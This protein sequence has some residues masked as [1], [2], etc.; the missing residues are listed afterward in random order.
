MVLVILSISPIE[1][2]YQEFSGSIVFCRYIHLLAIHF[3]TASL[4]TVWQLLSFRFMKNYVTPYWHYY[5][6]PY[7]YYFSISYIYMAKKN[8]F[9][10]LSANTIVPLSQIQKMKTP[11]DEVIFTALYDQPQSI[12]ELGITTNIPINILTTKI[13]SIKGSL[14]RKEVIT[15]WKSKKVVYSVTQQAEKIADLLKKF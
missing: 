12:K 15:E 4:G 9:R 6:K 13:N 11:I 8:P 1:S 10:G 2:S 14:L 3:D 5:F 7:I